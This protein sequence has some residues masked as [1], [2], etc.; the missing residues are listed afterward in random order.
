[1]S[2]NVAAAPLHPAYMTALEALA[3]AIADTSDNEIAVLVDHLA[4]LVYKTRQLHDEAVATGNEVVAQNTLRFE[5][6]VAALAQSMVDIGTYRRSWDKLRCDLMEAMMNNPSS[7][8]EP[9]PH[10]KG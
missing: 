4:K 1:M 9:G 3:R 10:P 7:E 6:I 8:P 5:A 2:D